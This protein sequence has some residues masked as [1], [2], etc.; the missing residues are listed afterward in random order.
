MSDPGAW[1]PDQYQR[2][3][4]ERSWPFF[5]LVALLRPVDH[6]RIVDLG[7]GTGAL[8]QQLHMRMEAADTLGIDHAPAMLEQAR[9]LAGDG[10]HFE[11]GDIAEFEGEKEYDV[12]CSNAALQ[13]VTD[14]RAVLERWTAAL[15]PN[16]QLAVQVP[17]NVDHPAHVLA[18][19]VASEPPF[20]DV[21]DGRPPLD[22]VLSVLKPEDYAV[23]LDE[24][25][26]EEQHVRLHVYGHQ[27]A[28]T[29]DVVEWVKGTSLTRFRKGMGPELY[30][31][32]VERF[33][34]R[35]LAQLGDRRPFFYPFKRILFW[36]RKP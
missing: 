16:G 9:P 21:F 27:L 19:V 17:A 24:L 22:P 34:E 32:F 25:G 23:V 35:L 36:G 31:Q 3:G 2:F 6:A 20:A 11:Q 8:T 1:Q 18:A 15:A 28:S 4:A 5:D 12:V 33:R 7:C 14:H 29:G 13:W 26:F 10:L 30:D